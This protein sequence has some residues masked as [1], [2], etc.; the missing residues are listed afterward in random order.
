MAKDIK[1]DNSQKPEP[2]D[3]TAPKDTKEPTRHDNL[4]QW[5]ELERNG[6][7]GPLNETTP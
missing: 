1:E 7:E 2:K 4:L 3:I 5:P 6:P